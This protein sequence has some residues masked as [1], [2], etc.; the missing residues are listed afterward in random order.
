MFSFERNPKFVNFTNY[1][2]DGEPCTI[3]TT[4]GST[5]IVTQIISPITNS[6][7]IQ[8]KHKHKQ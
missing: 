6:G 7:S 4:K 3:M 1:V 8:K 5:F 2:Y